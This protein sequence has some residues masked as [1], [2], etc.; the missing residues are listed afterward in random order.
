MDTPQEKISYCIGIEVGKNLTT[1]FS[2]LNLDLLI[3]GFQDAIFNAPL[4]LEMEEI[5]AVLQ[6][7]RKQ[8]EL[9]QR[10]FVK[11]TAEENKKAGEEFQEQHRNKEGVVTLPSG[12]QY[13]VLKAGVG[14]SPTMFD[15]VALHFKGSFLDGRTFESTYEAKKPQL[16]AMN[17]VI[18][19]WSEVLQMM[20]EGD[21][22]EVVVPSYLAHGVNGLQGR[23][24][25]NTTLMFDLELIEVN[26]AVPNQR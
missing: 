8:V 26:P 14:K 3:K 11:R 21:K 18:S 9:Q 24:A 12:L 25:P 23:I 15:L 19:G 4:Q 17:Q 5:K 16:L 13:R 1:Q 22:W 20:R 2:D 6:T 10:E 7:L